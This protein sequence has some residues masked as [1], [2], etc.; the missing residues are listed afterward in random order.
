MSRDMFTCT[1]FLA[2]LDAYFDGVLDPVQSLRLEGHHHACPSC[3]AAY[4]PKAREKFLARG[5]FD[6]FIAGTPEADCLSDATLQEYRDGLLT[7]EEAALAREHLAE[8]IPCA[9]GRDFL[10]EEASTLKK[11]V[12]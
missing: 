2:Q 9:R 7:D 10:K 1:Q 11:P 4:R 5:P 12:A 8:C 3:Q 6:M